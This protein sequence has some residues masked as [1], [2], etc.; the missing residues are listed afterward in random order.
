M[1]E[2]MRTPL[3]VVVMLMLGVASRGEGNVA[4]VGD[5][6]QQPPGPARLFVRGGCSHASQ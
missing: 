6:E 2:Q 3:I 4:R 1:S 5:L